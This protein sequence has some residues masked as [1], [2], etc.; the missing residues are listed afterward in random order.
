MGLFSKPEVVFVKES[1]DAK[2]YLA[3]LE[4]LLPTTQGELHKQIQKEIAV[5]KA[6]IAGENNIIFELKNSNLDMVVLHDIYIETQ[7][8]LGAQIDFIVITPKLIYL[9]EC[10]NLFGNLEIDSKG[11]FIRTIEYGGKKHK[12][13]I[14][15]PITQNDRHMEVLKECNASERNFI[16]GAVVRG[17]F[18]RYYRS[19]IILANPKTV[20]NDRYAKKEVKEQVHRADQLISIIKK[21]NAES[22]ELSSSKK[23]M[24][25]IA[26]R[27]LSKNIDER[28]DYFEKY[29]EL[30]KQA[31]AEVKDKTE[32]AITSE[33]N[34]KPACPKCGAEL[35]M[36][37]AK[38]GANIGQK[39]YGCSNYPKCRYTLNVKEK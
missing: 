24:M 6:G 20:V 17:N 7:N 2:E 8:G 12:E 10:K 21:M 27:L 14:Y 18:N 25:S 13:G 38:K 31:E 3:K 11:N 5:T 28:K 15:S 9:I 30:V 22:K 39:F 33:I 37:T 26:E 32:T 35:V 1:S 34:D 19:L 16:M 36:R 29:K 23:E 4:K